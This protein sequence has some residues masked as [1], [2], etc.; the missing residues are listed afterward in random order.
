[1]ITFDN[2]QTEEDIVP[3]M[4]EGLSISGQAIEVQR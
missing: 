4:G 2:A 1:M 3:A